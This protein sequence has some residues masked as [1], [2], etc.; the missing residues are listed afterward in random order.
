M[1]T[2]LSIAAN[3]R[4]SHGYPLHV[5]T[6]VLRGRARKIDS[7]ALVYQRQKRLPSIIAKLQRFRSMQLATMQDLGGCRAVLRSVTSVDNLVKTYE[8]LPTSAG[9]FV[10]KKDYI[11]EPKPDGYRSV[12][13]IY[14]Y[15]GRHQNGAYCGLKTEIQ[16]RSRLQH[17][18]ATALETIDIFTNQALKSGLGSDAWKR[19][20]ALM[21]TAIALREERPIVP[22]TPGNYQDLI[23]ELRPT[24]TKLRI[25][26]MFYALSQ[27]VKMASGRDRRGAASHILVLDTDEKMVTVHSFLT[28]EDAAEQYIAIEKENLSKPNIQS[29]MVSVDSIQALKSAY[30]SYYLDTT[31]FARIARELIDGKL[32][33]PRR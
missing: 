31:Q 18:W 16:I 5:F 29:V 24:C 4:S 20:F 19:F 30:P 33:R 8:E 11:Q 6:K 32:K 15:Q 23:K 17:A 26:D 3:W 10:N 9:R 13:L 22:G 28:N 12:H 1:D 27:G 2:A 7:R 21:A 25:P 14:E